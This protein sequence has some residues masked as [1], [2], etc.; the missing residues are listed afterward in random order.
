MTVATK[1]QQLGNRLITKFGTN[2]KLVR[3]DTDGNVTSKQS[4]GCITQ[5][6]DDDIVDGFITFS[7]KVCW[8]RGDIQTL[9][10][11][12]DVIQFVQSKNTYTVIQM[13][14]YSPDDLTNCA[15]RLIVR[16]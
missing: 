3:T 1:F 15:F 5:I 12:G 10:Q 13:K 16:P 8:V 6:T 4:K 14:H 2:I 11:E 7:D 9:P